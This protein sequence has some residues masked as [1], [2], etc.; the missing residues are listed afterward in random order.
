[1]MGQNPVAESLDREAVR[2][3]RAR[4]P[5]A[6]SPQ[7]RNVTLFSWGLQAGGGD[8]DILESWKPA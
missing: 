5:P 2:A 1:M 3:Q 6:W 8:K 7:E 4:P